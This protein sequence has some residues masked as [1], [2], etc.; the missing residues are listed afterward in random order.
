MSDLRDTLNGPGGAHITSKP[1][2]PPG[3]A[4]PTCASSPSRSSRRPAG[5]VSPGSYRRSE[6]LGGSYQRAF[7]D[8]AATMRGRPVID[9]LPLLRAAAVGARF[10]FTDADL[11]EQVAAIDR[12][13]R[14]ELRVWITRP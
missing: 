3:P 4:S 8:L 6:G 2:P 11:A 9:I 7:T 14:Y 5:G 10:A 13:G 1:M 12:G